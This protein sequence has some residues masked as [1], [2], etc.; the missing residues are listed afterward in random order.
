MGVLS[1]RDNKLQYLPAEVG[2]CTALHVLDVSGNRL[3]YL[4]YSLI[5]LNLKAVWLSENQAQPMLTFQTDI[6]EETE[7]EVLTCFLLPQLEFHPDDSG[8]LGMLVGIRNAVQGGEIRELA[9]SDDEGWQE[10]EASR[11]HSVKFTDE[12]PEVDKET[13]FVRQNTPHPKELK[14][15]AHKLFSKGKSESRSGSTDEQDVSQTFGLDKSDID[16]KSDGDGLEMIAAEQQESL[17]HD[18]AENDEKNPLPGILADGEN[19][20]ANSQQSDGLPKQYLTESNADVVTEDSM[21]ESKVRQDDDDDDDDESEN[22]EMQRHVEFSI[23]ENAD[24][25][26]GGDTNRPNRLH[27]RDTPHHLKNK[28]IHAAIDKEKV[29]SI[30][31][32]V[33]NII[34]Q[35]LLHPCQRPRNL[36]KTLTVTVKVQHP[37]LNQ[38]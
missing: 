23:I 22:E 28:R 1:L 32:Q 17:K 16:V 21:L 18:G 38:R 20:P 19:F 14:A 15:K 2:Q 10:R 25:E 8:R 30:I 31:A 35:H 24:Y 27:R 3:Q 33:I 4:P 29:A 9:S 6:D 7:Q 12:P 26:S 36:Q 37:M 11:T 13:P 34:F 5:N